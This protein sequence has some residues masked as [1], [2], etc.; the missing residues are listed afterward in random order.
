MLG[1]SDVQNLRQIFAPVQLLYAISAGLPGHGGANYSITGPAGVATGPN[2]MF[3][4]SGVTQGGAGDDTFTFS[5]GA[6]L[7][8]GATFTIPDV[9]A[10]GAMTVSGATQYAQNDT[11]LLIVPSG[12]TGPISQGWMGQILSGGGTTSLV[13][14]TTSLGTLSAG[15]TIANG[16][17]ITW[18]QTP[19]T[20]GTQPRIVQQATGS[21]AS[22]SSYVLTL[23]GSPS[24]GNRMY[25]IVTANSGSTFYPPSGWN[26]I[27]SGAGNVNSFLWAYERDVQAGDLTT[28]TLSFS[29]SPGESNGY[30]GEVTG[31][32]FGLQQAAIFTGGGTHTPTTPAVIPYAPSSLA[33]GY[34]DG[35]QLI[36]GADPGVDGSR[37]CRR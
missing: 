36:P 18:G 3:T 1:P 26:L 9:G 34:S 31:G 4:G 8:L 25:L 27:N 15:G 11:S 23:P 22:G 21:L 2:W 33:L 20:T 30:I 28:Y 35:A 14:Q 13:V 5:G 16:T 32:A 19:T 6:T 29:G 37:A 12:F 17:N 24:V 10:T 7:A